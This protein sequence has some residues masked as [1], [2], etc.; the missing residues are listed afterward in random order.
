M[1]TKDRVVY[2][3]EE[4]KSNSYKRCRGVKNKIVTFVPQFSM[5]LVIF[6]CQQ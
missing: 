3:F 2:H 4:N 6:C 5:V 1:K